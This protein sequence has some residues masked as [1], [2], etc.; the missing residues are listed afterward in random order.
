MSNLANLLD[1]YMNITTRIWRQTWKDDLVVRT[2]RLE[3]NSDIG[4][5]G[6]GMR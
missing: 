4:S 3:D 2:G 5:L 1:L 6:W